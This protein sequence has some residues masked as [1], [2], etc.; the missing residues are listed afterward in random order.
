M[1]DDEIA[2]IIAEEAARRRIQ[3]QTV[4]VGAYLEREPLPPSTRPGDVNMH[5]LGRTVD[6]VLG[7]NRRNQ[8]SQCWQQRNL[9]SAVHSLGNASRE[10]CVRKRPRSVDEKAEGDRVQAKSSPSDAAQLEQQASR[11]AWALK[12]AA[13]VA[14]A[15]GTATSS[16]ET[17]R[18]SRLK[19]DKSEKGRSKKR[20]KKEAKKK[21]RKQHKEE[22]KRSKKEKH[23][24]DSLSSAS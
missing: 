15:Q 2:R 7:H 21:K 11:E 17:S 20:E 13:Q 6:A 10:P 9:E 12:K 23:K 24:G 5:F 16:V 22:R 3:A 18:G 4:G 1:S 8:E 19:E 14:A